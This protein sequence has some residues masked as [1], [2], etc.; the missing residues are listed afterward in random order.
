MPRA[1]KARALPI[2]PIP[3]KFSV[4][5]VEYNITYHCYFA[6]NMFRVS[7]SAMFVY[8]LMIIFCGDE[9][10]FVVKIADQRNIFVQK[11]LRLNLLKFENTQSSCL[12]GVERM[13]VQL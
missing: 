1:C 5:L 4:Y 6:V 13:R 7:V 2:A 10:P 12:E 8:F 9:P 3:R 11:L